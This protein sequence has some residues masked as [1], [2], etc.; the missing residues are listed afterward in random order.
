MCLRAIDQIA[1][2]VPSICTTSSFSPYCSV[3]LSTMVSILSTRVLMSSCSPCVSPRQ[4]SRV[5]ESMGTMAV[6]PTVFATLCT[7]LLLS[8]RSC[9]ACSLLV[10]APL[11]LVRARVRLPSRPRG[12][13]RG[14]LRLA[15]PPPC[16]ARA[17]WS[18]CFW[19][20]LTAR[21]STC[22][23]THEC[24]RARIAVICDSTSGGAD[25]GATI[26]LIR[27]LKNLHPLLI[28]TSAETSARACASSSPPSAYV[29]VDFYWSK[30][31]TTAAARASRR[32]ASL[33]TEHRQSATKVPDTRR[34]S[35]PR[36]VS[37]RRRLAPTRPHDRRQ[38]HTLQ[39][40][41]PPPSG[42]AA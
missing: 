15:S 11:S 26:G 21:F 37:P 10:T 5:D 39:Q 32:A 29:P 25:A 17:I 30:S 42:T 33:A 3:A 18:T 22:G 31:R 9:R 34:P 12:A 7:A 19:R 27:T 40:Q 36:C 41:H 20:R 13:V 2:A 38:V 6:P 8:V 4:W 1:P 16:T 23:P 14:A 28:R 35:R 24:A